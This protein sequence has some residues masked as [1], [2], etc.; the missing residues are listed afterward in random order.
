LASTHDDQRLASLDSLQIS[1]EIALYFLD[2]D[3][4]HNAITPRKFVLHGHVL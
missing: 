1:R 2:P 3:P 4:K